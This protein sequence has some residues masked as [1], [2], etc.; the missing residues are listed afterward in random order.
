VRRF[1]KTV[2]VVERD[3]A[4]DVLLDGKPIKTPRRKNLSVPTRRLAEAIALE[5][6]AQGEQIELLSMP[7]IRL[8]TAAMDRG[9]HERGQV[10][11][12]ILRY[13]NG[14][15]LCYRAEDIELAERQRTAWDAVLGCL[16]VTHCARLEVTTGLSHIAQ[17]QDALQRLGEVVEGC[18]P[19]ALTA[20]HATATITGSI[21]LALA[22]LAGRLG[23]AEAFALSQLD[24]TYQ[25]EKWG[26]DHTAAERAKNLARELE[27]AAQFAVLSR[28]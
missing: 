27:S 25:A 4:F 10:V 18:D 24:E 14:D 12:D 8:A 23:A 26:V 5:W 22:L 13:A 2:S 3:G 9:S 28:P 11:A 7:L 20:L 6:R 17:P 16:D 15:L 1:Y 21:T 19:Y